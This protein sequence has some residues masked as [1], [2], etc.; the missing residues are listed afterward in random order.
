MR[1]PRSE[2][3][4]AWATIRRLMKSGNAVTSWGAN[5]SFFE[6]WPVELINLPLVLAYCSL[7]EALDQLII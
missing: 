5:A 6:R 2:I 4:A 1:S 3:A 7:E